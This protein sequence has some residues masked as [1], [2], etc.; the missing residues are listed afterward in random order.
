M[1]TLLRFVAAAMLLPLFLARPAVGQETF[2][3]L[4]SDNCIVFA[5]VDF[6]KVE[7]DTLKKQIND[8]GEQFVDSLGFDERSRAATLRE[9]KVELDKLD[10]MV[11]SDYE[12]L[13]KELGVRELAVI[14]DLDLIQNQVIAIVAIPWKDKTE[15]DLA[16]FKKLLK[17]EDD[18]SMNEF[19]MVP[20]FL[21]APISDRLGTVE[22]W[23]NA[24]E[25]SPKSRIY[26]A[27]KECGN[28]ELKI[29]ATLPEQLTAI[30]LA[31]SAE[32]DLP[33]EAAATLIFMAQKIEWASASFSLSNVAA[34]KDVTTLLTLKASSE[35]D[36][37]QIRAMLEGLI[38][39]GI[40]M[41]QVEM[42]RNQSSEFQPPPLLFEFMRG[43]MRT[44]LPK[45]DGDRLRFQVEGAGAQVTQATIAVGGIGTALLLP[46]VQAA[47]E[48]ARRMQ[49]SNNMK[50]IGLAMH[51]FHSAQNS[52][53]PLYTVDADGK[54]LHS[55]RVL[56]LPYMEQQALYDMIRLDEP[57][58]SEHNSQFHE[59]VIQ[60]YRC[61]SNP[62]VKPGADC[63]YSVI[64]G[65]GLVPNKKPGLRNGEHSF[66]RITDG[67]SNT[68]FLVE[69]RE[70]FCWMDPK[71]DMTLEDLEH[72]INTPDGQAGSYHQGGMNVG[73]FD[74]SVR[75]ISDTIDK[76]VLRAI[77]T[78]AGGESRTF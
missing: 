65:E 10:K 50:Q 78:C 66:A 63:C 54:P 13:T 7:I 4:I 43:C 16:I 6:S 38:D 28:A 11:R 32:M 73:M 25:P 29:A 64:A 14:V 51:N 56:L 40:A 46:A 67:T 27:L 76:Q 61:P 55:W 5:Q 34:D 37:I 22:E 42:V 68:V 35:A 71:A 12:T 49:C 23:F 77:G 57:W 36:A 18:S 72:G 3:P 70:P 45:V 39:F 52:L 48:A 31:A 8:I 75:Y 24:V 19:V 44:M 33:K 47:R 2:A 69:V 30:V 58:D 26:E 74:G 59:L 20:G 9:L 62:N 41:D 60:I 21:L 53:P 17:I 1:K 15:K